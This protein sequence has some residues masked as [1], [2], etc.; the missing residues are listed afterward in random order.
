MTELDL[1]TKAEYRA[2]VEHS[3]DIVSV[4]D[5]TGRIQY[6]SPSV[7]RVLGYDQGALVGERAF[8]YVH[9]DDREMVAELFTRMIEHPDADP[10]RVE[11]RFRHAD[12]SWIWLEANGSNRAHTTL[13]GYVVNCREITE[14][15]ERERQLARQNERLEEFASIVSHDLRNPLGIVEGSIELYHETGD[16]EHYERCLEAIERMDRLVED[17]LELARQDTSVVDVEPVDVV[18]VTRRAWEAA[19]RDAADLTVVDGFGVEADPDQFRRLL[20]NL[21][22]NAV[23]HGLAAPESRDREES[24]GSDGD[25]GDRNG[26][27]VTLGRTE[28]GFY[29]ADDGPGIPPGER[30]AVFEPGY[31]TSAEGTG[32]GLRIVDRIVRAH[33]WDVAVTDSAAGGARF[34]VTGVE[35]TG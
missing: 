28:E 9:P 22:E 7:E 24:A 18:D 13:D 14:R 29:V 8:E 23:R 17:L 6:H 4:L 35:F 32:Y 12:G 31:S 26:V 33:G 16:A 1:D 2:L 19:D 27:S 11:F 15:R 34:D 3:S 10:R 25:G 30:E 5:E 20:E 21:L